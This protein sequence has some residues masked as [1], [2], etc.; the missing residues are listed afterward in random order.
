MEPHPAARRRSM[1][2]VPVGG[3]PPQPADIERGFGR[4]MRAAIGQR[5]G[6]G[7]TR[8][9]RRRARRLIRL[10]YLNFHGID[11]A[12]HQSLQLRIERGLINRRRLLW[13]VE[14]EAQQG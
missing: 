12:A 11:P 13:Q 14:D 7:I 4:A 3:E 6:I 2:L 9:D 10:C 1:A 5:K 8:R